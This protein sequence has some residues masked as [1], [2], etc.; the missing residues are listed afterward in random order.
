MTI[1]E[2]AN[3]AAKSG[4]LDARIV[5]RSEKGESELNRATFT[6]R[7][8]SNIV[9]PSGVFNRHRPIVIIE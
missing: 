7:T 5:I 6:Y 9:D 4:K 1:R 2:L 3:E 8:D